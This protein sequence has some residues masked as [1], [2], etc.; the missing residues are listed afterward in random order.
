MRR[1]VVFTGAIFGG[2]EKNRKHVYVK[3]LKEF[4]W[5]TSETQGSIYGL[6]QK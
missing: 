3:N 6:L 1:L 2:V 4:G 5:S